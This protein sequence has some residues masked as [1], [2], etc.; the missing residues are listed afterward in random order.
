[1]DSFVELLIKNGDGYVS[2]GKGNDFFLGNA[3]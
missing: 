2:V 1:M 3:R